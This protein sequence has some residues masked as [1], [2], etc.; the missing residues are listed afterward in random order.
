MAGSLWSLIG[1]IVVTLP[2]KDGDPVNGRATP[3]NTST[4]R[5]SIKDAGVCLY[6][7]DVNIHEGTVWM[8]ATRAACH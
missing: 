3:S 5:V 4:L 2:D 6:V 7:D 1:D 8:K